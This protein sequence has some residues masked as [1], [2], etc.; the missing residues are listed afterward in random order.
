MIQNRGVDIAT[1][2]EQL[3]SE[4]STANRRAAQALTKTTTEIDNYQSEDII[5]REA[6]PELDLNANEEPANGTALSVTDGELDTNQFTVTSELSEDA[7]AG[8][9]G[10]Y[11][12]DSDEGLDERAAS[13]YGFQI[14]EDG[15][16]AGNIPAT[17]IVLK[18]S[19]GGEIAE[20]DLSAL[21]NAETNAVII[22][23]PV[24]LAKQDVRMTI[25]ITEADASFE[26]KPLV[27]VAEQTGDN[28]NSSGPFASSFSA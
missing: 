1:T 26:L 2:E 5:V 13:L 27:A 17:T 14:P 24:V 19:N 15:E 6:I 23:D 28:F 11:S 10:F 20:Y 22:Q 21:A 3:D 8:E 25:D 4:Q 9:Y 16:T 18:N 7:G 12:L